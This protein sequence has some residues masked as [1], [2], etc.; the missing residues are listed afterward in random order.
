MPPP[1]SKFAGHSRVDLGAVKSNAKAVF[2]AAHKSTRELPANLLQ[3]GG[4]HVGLPILYR[5]LSPFVYTARSFRLSR[6]ELH[7]K[8][9]TRQH[10]SV[11]VCISLER[12]NRKI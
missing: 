9:P 10:L 3:D 11:F 4:T 2:H 8:G 6:L 12:N 7:I 5:A 1:W